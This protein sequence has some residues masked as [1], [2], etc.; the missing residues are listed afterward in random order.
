MRSPG[1]R[2]KKALAAAAG[3]AAADDADETPR[4]RTL[5]ADVG[6]RVAH[7]AGSAMPYERVLDTRVT[8]QAYLPR[9]AAFIV[10]A[11][12][13]SHLDMGLVKYALGD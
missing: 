9:R 4:A 1:R 13:A 3:R 7:A 8:G 10:A 2:K 12:H 5:V 6:R 11:N